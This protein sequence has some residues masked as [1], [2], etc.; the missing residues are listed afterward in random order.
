MKKKLRKFVV[1]IVL[2]A[3]L[4]LFLY[5]YMYETDEMYVLSV[6]LVVVGFIMLYR[7]HFILHREKHSSAA[8]FQTV[9]DQDEDDDLYEDAKE[10]VIESGK[11]STSYLQ[12]K[13]RLGYS[14]SARLMDML[15]ENGVIGPQ[16][17]A[18]PREVLLE[19][20]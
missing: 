13:L 17:G 5:D 11:A 3:G 16:D 12:R 10:A 18:K 4:I 1:E 14:R 20:E 8:F 15:E 2:G 9:V 6:P 7:R 19:Q